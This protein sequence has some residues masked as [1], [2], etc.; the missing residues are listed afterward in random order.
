[1]PQICYF[2]GI[3]IYMQFLD[4][5]PPHVHATYSGY[6]GSY[7]INTGSLIAGGMPPR[8]TKLIEEWIHLRKEKLL[9]DWS[10]AS[11]G[12]QIFPIEPLE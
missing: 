6:K 3:T 4:H 12:K 1:M 11:A 5:N 10:L 8:A 9:E 7:D 2:L